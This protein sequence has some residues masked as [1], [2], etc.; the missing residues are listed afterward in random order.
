MSADQHIEFL[1]PAGLYRDAEYAYA[2]VAPP[3][4]LVFSAGACPVDADGVVVGAGDYETQARK[5]VSNLFEA[6]AAAGAAPGDILKTTV[7]VVTLSHDELVAAW[8]AVK[9]AFEPFDPPSTLLG[10]SV[11]GYTEQLV[12]IEAVALVPAPSDAA[13]SPE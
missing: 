8:A 11:L 7:F 3:G 2:A 6:L 4:R 5:T 13:P 1:R 9:A 10:V 12:E